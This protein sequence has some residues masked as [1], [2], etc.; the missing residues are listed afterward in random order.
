M[1]KILS[2][3]LN[4]EGLTPLHRVCQ[5]GNIK[6][7]ELFLKNGANPNA[8]GIFFFFFLFFPFLSFSLLLLIKN[9]L[10]I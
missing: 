8:F 5:T 6:L 4:Q 1:N 3:I 7:C 2:R 10:L 9:L